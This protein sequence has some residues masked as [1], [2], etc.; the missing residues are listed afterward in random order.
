MLRGIKLLRETQKSR[1]EAVEKFC[2]EPLPPTLT[3]AQINLAKS[4]VDCAL[5]VI[6]HDGFNDQS[7]EFFSHHW[8][9]N[10]RAVKRAVQK[11]GR[12]LTSVI[13]DLNFTND[14]KDPIKLWRGHPKTNTVTEAIGV[15]WTGSEDIAKHFAVKLY[16][17]EL[18]EGELKPAILDTVVC[19]SAILYTPDDRSEDEYVID[20]KMLDQSKIKME[21]LDSNG[22]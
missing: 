7:R 17:D 4:N 16:K 13:R 5:R 10:H 2:S 12:P 14:T 20:T 18:N 15:S 21:K 9:L 8:R 19:P 11:N 3:D 6:F 1:S 22:T